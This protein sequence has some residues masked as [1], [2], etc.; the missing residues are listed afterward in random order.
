MDQLKLSNQLVDD[1]IKTLT[2][3]DERAS[4]PLIASQYLAAI[5]GFT[6]GNQNMPVRDKREIID[7]LNAFSLHVFE[8]I[9]QQKQ[10]PPSS[11]S[12]EAFGKWKPK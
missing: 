8:D 1:I 4:D 2:A 10:P 9:N 12:A 7:Q 6:V 11:P 5:M 3:E